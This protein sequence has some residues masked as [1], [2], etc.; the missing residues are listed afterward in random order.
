MNKKLFLT[1]AIASSLCEA[2]ELNSNL[3][4]D[5]SGNVLCDS[6]G[7][8]YSKN[9]DKISRLSSFDKSCIRKIT[10]LLNDN[11]QAPL[12]CFD[13]SCMLL[14]ICSPKDNIFEIR[15]LRSYGSLID[16]AIHNAIVKTE[17]LLPT[18]LNTCDSS[19]CAP[20]MLYFDNH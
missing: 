17:P 7:F 3:K 2:Q 18:I 20:L 14:M 16:S 13:G 9:G 5:I 11:Y 19:F 10:L 1:I 6:N 12:I 8:Y 15:Q 4:Y